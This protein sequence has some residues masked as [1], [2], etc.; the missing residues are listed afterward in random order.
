MDKNYVDKQLDDVVRTLYSCTSTLW[1]PTGEN[2][3]FGIHSGEMFGGF[4]A[5]T[6]IRADNYDSL[7][8]EVCI[9]K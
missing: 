8:S 1:A 2:E 7:A 3:A 5:E 6:S 4:K 9:G